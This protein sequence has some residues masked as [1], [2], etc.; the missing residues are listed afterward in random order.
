[1]AITAQLAVVRQIWALETLLTDPKYA[2]AGRGSFHLGEIDLR[3]IQ[4]SLRTPETGPHTTLILGNFGAAQK[5]DTDA[6]PLVS[7]ASVDNVEKVKRKLDEAKTVTGLRAARLHT[8][9]AL[10]L[11]TQRAPAYAKCR[12]S[13]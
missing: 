10:R 2:V 7:V 11:H 9:S 12:R 4:V 1:M 5:F 6:V 8:Q 3:D 13:S